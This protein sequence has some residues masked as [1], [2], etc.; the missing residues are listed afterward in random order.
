MQS[1]KREAPKSMRPAAAA[2]VAVPSRH[3]MKSLRRHVENRLRR[4]LPGA[5]H[6]HGAHH[7]LTDVVPAVERLCDGEGIRGKDRDILLAAALFHDTGFIEAY[8]AN[9]PIGARIAADTLPLYGFSHAEVLKVRSLILAT[10]MREVDGVWRQVPGEDPLKRILCDADLDNLGRTDFFQVSDSLRRELSE[11][12]TEFS[13]LEWLTRQVLFASQ[14]EWFTDS[15]RT[16]RQ[17]G[18]EA[19]LASLRKAL[20]ALL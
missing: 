9:E 18:K 19:N 17:A 3:R 7:T 8:N 4:E 10:E 14:Q 6:Y 20:S 11:Q 13:E 5:L 1:A 15:Q 12:G 16:A 2:P